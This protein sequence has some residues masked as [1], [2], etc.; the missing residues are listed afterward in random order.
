[1][2][3]N[4]SIQASGKPEDVQIWRQAGIAEIKHALERDPTQA[5]IMAMLIMLELSLNQEA[6]AQ[7]YYTHFKH[8]AKK[9][10][11]LDKVDR[12]Q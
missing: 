10:A 5:D 2:L 3:G 1:M 7:Q 4:L 11:L 9:S 8:I 6:E 12:L